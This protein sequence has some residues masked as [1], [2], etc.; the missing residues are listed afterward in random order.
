[1]KTAQVRQPFR[2]LRD[3]LVPIVDRLGEASD[4][5]SSVLHQS[6]EE[7]R[8][9]EFG[10]DVLEDIGYDF[11]RGR[12]DRSTH[13]FTTTFSVDDV[14]I[15]TRFDPEEL[16]TGLFG[17]LHEGGHAL[18]EQGI[19]AS[20]ER[21]PLAEG[22]SLG[23]HESQS[24]LWENMIGR[25]RPFW[26]QYLPELKMVFPEQ[27]DGVS[28]LSFYRAINTV[29]PSLIRVEADEV[30]YNLHIMIRFEIEQ[31]LVNEEISVVDVP[32]MWR[33][34]MEEYLGVSPDSYTEGSLQDIHWSLGAFGY[35]PTY[36]LGNLMAAQLFETMSG[37]I[38]EIDR[39]IA[40]GEFE[41]LL[42][43]LRENVH[44][45]GRKFTGDE[46]LERITGSCLTARPWLRYIRDK[47][48]ELYD[49]DL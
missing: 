9:W 6:F 25:S 22:A 33:D 28:L 23:M 13:P 27:L 14:R 47:Y 35:F 36:A 48:S 29:Y 34:L 10:V 20:L 41:E 5:D 39:Q 12:Q 21:T 15:T 40:A 43:W 30:T 49:I 19:E 32:E 31:A 17:S 18:Y 3:E 37:D 11:D 38:P 46:L 16:S 2:A 26:Q 7:Q 4:P 24:R 8:Q 45:H 42:E 1:M 44:R